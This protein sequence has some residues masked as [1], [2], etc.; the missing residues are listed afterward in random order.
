MK[1]IGLWMKVW[2]RCRLL[3]WRTKI[4][5]IIDHFEHFKAEE[6]AK[7]RAPVFARQSAAVLLNFVS[8]NSQPSQF[9]GMRVEHV[10][11]T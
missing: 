11:V 2:S 7:A 9:F 4:A 6:S 1:S 8:C 10:K 3:G 5:L